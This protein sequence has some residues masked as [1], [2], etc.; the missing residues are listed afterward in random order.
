MS[1]HQYYKN[2]MVKTSAS[3]M[4]YPNKTR[5]RALLP[6]LLYKTVPKWSRSPN[7]GIRVLFF[8]PQTVSN[9]RQKNGEI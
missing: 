5:A 3:E 8:I 7:L 2:N 6:Y 9:F 1:Q 4:K